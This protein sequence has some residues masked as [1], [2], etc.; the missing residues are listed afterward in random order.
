MGPLRSLIS[1]FLGHH[2]LGPSQQEP[3]INWYLAIPHRRGLEEDNG[4][5]VCKAASF[6]KAGPG[7]TQMWVIKLVGTADGS[8]RNASPV[9]EELFELL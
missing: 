2:L 9:H 4:Q 5:F 7:M 8:G 1:I 3:L 6:D